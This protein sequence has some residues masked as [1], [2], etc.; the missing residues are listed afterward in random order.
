MVSHSGGPVQCN[1][2]W[3]SKRTYQIVC[4]GYVIASI[5]VI[6]QSTAESHA[7]RQEGRAEKSRQTDKQTDK[8]RGL[9]WNTH[10]HTRI[11]T[12]LRQAGGISLL[13]IIIMKRLHVEHLPLRAQRD[14]RSVPATSAHTHMHTHTYLILCS[15]SSIPP[16]LPPPLPLTI[17][18]RAPKGFSSPCTT[19]TP[20]PPLLPL[21]PVLVSPGLH[22]GL[23]RCLVFRKANRWKRSKGYAVLSPA[24]TEHSLTTGI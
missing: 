22:T 18:T 20:P 16:L 4:S 6:M 17:F 9:M 7:G 12:A 8:E 2:S 23:H 15:S 5:K 13:L 1:A 19:R 21:C 10:K 11:H 24:G 3:R 14:G